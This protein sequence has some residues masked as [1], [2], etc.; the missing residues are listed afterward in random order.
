MLRHARLP[1]PSYEQV[2]INLWRFSLSWALQAVKKYFITEI[3]GVNW[4]KGFWLWMFF[5]LWLKNVFYFSVLLTIQTLNCSHLTI[6]MSQASCNFSSASPLTPKVRHLPIITTD[7]VINCE[8]LWRNCPFIC[9]RF[10]WKR[11]HKLVLRI[12]CAII[13]KNLQMKTLK[14]GHPW[15]SFSLKQITFDWIVRFI[16]S[17]LNVNT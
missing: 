1:L 17:H 3:T 6:L 2:L 16:K 10:F 8:P 15:F 11:T 14:H 13:H 5:S 7:I 9:M 12:N 4:Q